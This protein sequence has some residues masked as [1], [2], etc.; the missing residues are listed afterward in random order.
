MVLDRSAAQPLGS[1][2]E[3]LDMVT[4][5]RDGIQHFD[6]AKITTGAGVR[7]GDLSFDDAIAKLLSA[8]A[9][10]PQSADAVDTNMTGSMFSAF[11]NADGSTAVKT[12][13]ALAVICKLVTERLWPA[14][15]T[16]GEW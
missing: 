8:I 10:T 13:A 14:M 1:F 3:I 11:T 9:A 12:V 16:D 5:Q 2:A 6:R 4:T 7:V 15:S